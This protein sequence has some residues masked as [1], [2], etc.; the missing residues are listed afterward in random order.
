M[1]KPLIHA[2][3]HVLA[4]IDA[5][6]YG[7][8]VAE[9]A[10]WAALRLAAPLELLHTL[11]RGNK[12]VSADLSGNLSLGGQEDLL[13]KLAD[14]DEQRARLGQEHGRVLLEQT[15]SHLI[16]TC[17]VEARVLQRH[18]GLADSLLELEQAVRLFVLGKRGELAALDHKDAYM[19][20]V[21]MDIH[22]KRSGKRLT[23]VALAQLTGEP[24][25][26]PDCQTS[27]SVQGLPSSQPVLSALSASRSDAASCSV[28]RAFAGPVTRMSVAP[29]SA[30]SRMPARLC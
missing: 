19:A 18:G 22:R 27:Y 21:I 23:R 16:H 20:K 3:G 29:F 6:L 14:L 1:S 26:T 7:R 17:G 11:E 5:S 10:A 9:L 12:P 25:Q 30:S 24:V 13:A 2:D 4:A 28:S 15:R 8:S